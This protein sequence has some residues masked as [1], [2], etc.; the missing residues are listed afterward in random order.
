M[1]GTFVWPMLV[2]KDI[3][4]GYCSNV[5]K[6]GAEND[7]RE[8]DF[9]LELPA[10][11]LSTLWYDENFCSATTLCPVSVFTM[12]T[13]VTLS[14]PS[15]T[16][17]VTSG[18]TDLSRPLRPLFRPYLGPLS[19]LKVGDDVLL[20]SPFCVDRLRCPLSTNTSN[21]SKFSAV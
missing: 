4:E 13:N 16:N 8:E 20:R 14:V 7:R 2:G 6:L 11:D 15:A 19:V 9:W 21:E 3:S 18:E 12:L 17:E 10:C 1:L 5:D